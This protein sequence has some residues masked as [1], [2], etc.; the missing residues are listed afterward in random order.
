[1]NKAWPDR[2]D[3]QLIRLTQYL[4]G[5]TTRQNEWRE[6]GK[7]LVNFFDADLVAFGKIDADKRV[8]TGKMP[9]TTPTGNSDDLPGKITVHD[10]IFSDRQ[11]AETYGE[12]VET[13]K[14]TMGQQIKKA[15]AETLQS[16]F[17]TSRLFADPMAISLIFLPVIRNSH[18]TAV[19]IVGYQ[20]GETFP[21]D[22][23]NLFIAIAGLVG[24]ITSR[25][26]MERELYS[27]REHLETLVKERTAALTKINEQ[28]L[29]EAGL[30]RQA[31]SAL[32]ESER[33]FQKMLGVVPDMIS[34]Q[35]PEF[36]IL[37]SN[38]QGLAAV[39]ENR[40]KLNTKCYKTYQ[41][42]DGICPG[43]RPQSVLETRKPIHEETRLPDG[44]WVALR[45]IPFLDKNNHV[46][47]FME[48][49]RDITEQKL[50][51][52]KILSL[53]KSESLGRMAGAVAHHFNNQ[54]SVVMGNLELVLQ[55]LPGDDENRKNLLQAM[56]A[57]RKAADVSRQILNYLGP[58]SGTHSPVNLSDA[59]RQSL[60]LLQSAAPENMIVNVDFPD[61]GPV[62]RAD[63]GQIHQVLTHLFTNARESIVDDRGRID[64]CIHTVFHEDI[65][66]SNRFPPD[67]QPQNGSYA[68]LELSDTGCGIAHEDIEKVFDPFFT[69][70][71]TGRG[72]GLSVVMGIMKTHGGGITVDSELG[73]GSIFRVYL[74]TSAEKNR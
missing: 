15:V 41:G 44:R 31:D 19:M 59:C 10:W 35:G 66:A 74:P 68:C 22:L 11:S 6:V 67:W 49:V 37:Y 58:I 63:A 25:L 64:L 13:L 56:K 1:M 55:D 32:I 16:G 47:M 18:V 40:R 45:V 4:A 52:A 70:K 50:S 39:P 24:T 9:G 21:K 14:L 26:N 33:R 53:Q 2:K 72:L 8:P 60:S 69:N 17:F 29:T 51:E 7:A 65:A 3:F 23:L 54:L 30:R 12:S 61:A 27:H 57:A 42:F 28:L 48:W 43:C 36:D 46:E 34:I 73:C 5:L 62:V 71:F 38:W 20:A